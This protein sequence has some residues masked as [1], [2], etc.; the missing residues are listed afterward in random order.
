LFIKNI[1]SKFLQ[2]YNEMFRAQVSDKWY[3]STQDQNIEWEE[4]FICKCL[5]ST[6]GPLGC[7]WDVAPCHLYSERGQQQLWR[8]WNSEETCS[9]ERSSVSGDFYGRVCPGRWM[10]KTEEMRGNSP[11]CRESISGFSWIP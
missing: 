7:L 5:N 10:N 8:H 4:W 11:S 2:L 6:A 9:L 3:S 1:S